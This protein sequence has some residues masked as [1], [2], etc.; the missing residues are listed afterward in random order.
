[1]E[2]GHTVRS[3]T[4]G[5]PHLFTGGVPSERAGEERL[6]HK[7]VHAHASED[8][9]LMSGAFEDGEDI[10]REYS[11]EGGSRTPELSWSGVPDGTQSL[12][13]VVEDPDAP[14]PNP[15]L[16]WMLYDIAPAAS[17]ITGEVAVGHAGRN[18]MMQ[19]TWAGCAPPRGDS[20]HR[21]VFQLFALDRRLGLPDFSGRT[22]LLN[23]MK[24]RILGYT[25]LT[26][27]YQR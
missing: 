15:F 23:A 8:L 17:A 9:I 22:A 4:F 24:G 11:M 19:T 1:M 18:S 2:W 25:T 27:T 10:P 6:A 16:H 3:I 26:G 20:P 21:Y 13:L 14:T 12:A 7:R 5:L